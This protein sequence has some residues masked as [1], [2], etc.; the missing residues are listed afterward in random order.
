[1]FSV[2]GYRTMEIGG[3]WNFSLHSENVSDLGK[4]F[5]YI[6]VLFSHNVVHVYF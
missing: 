6:M 1:M 4:L 5:A 3:S 2:V